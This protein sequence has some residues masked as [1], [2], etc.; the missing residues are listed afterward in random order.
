MP[1]GHR[2]KCARGHLATWMNSP[3]YAIRR[4]PIYFWGSTPFMCHCG[5]QYEG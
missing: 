5:L 3:F 2:A 4:G 1:E